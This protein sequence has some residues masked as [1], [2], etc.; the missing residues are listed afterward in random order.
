MASPRPTHPD[1][2]LR[3]LRF[4]EREVLLEG[5]GTGKHRGDRVQD[6]MIALIEIQSIHS[7]NLCHGFEVFAF[8]C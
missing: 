6:L 2:A 4:D 1:P 5:P 3:P 8:A 7:L